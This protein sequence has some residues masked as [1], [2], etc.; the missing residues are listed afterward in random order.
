MSNYL[1]IVHAKLISLL[2]L[3]KEI[4]KICWLEQSN[5]FFLATLIIYSLYDGLIDMV[6]V[7]NSMIY[8]MIIL[9]KQ[10]LRTGKDNNVEAYFNNH[11]K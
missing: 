7:T 8:I 6:C 2:Q 5:V 3:K 1:I 4:K 9:A 11:T 10:A